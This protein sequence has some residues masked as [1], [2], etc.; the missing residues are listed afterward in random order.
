MLLLEISKKTKF[1]SHMVLFTVVFREARKFNQYQGFLCTCGHV[2]AQ[3]CINAK[4]VIR[5]FVI[6]VIINK[7][8]KQMM[9]IAQC[10]GHSY[11]RYWN[12]VHA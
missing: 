10:A 8:L 12:I 11:I 9:H 4:Y 2:M 5:V 6:F 1:Y 3:I 7:V